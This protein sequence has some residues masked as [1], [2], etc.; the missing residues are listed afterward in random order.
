MKR[1]LLALTLLSSSLAFG[2]SMLV[3]KNGKVLTFDDQGMVYDLGNFLLPYQIKKM[4]GRYVIDEDRKLRTVDNKGLM[5][6]KEE[7]DKV[8]VNID[9]FGENYFISKFGRM[10]TVDDLGYFY[11]GEEKERE[12]R[13]VRKA[14]GNFI[15]A[16]KKVDGKEVPAIFVIT[17]Q[18]SV[19]EVNVPGLKLLQVNY[20]GGNYFT[21]N[22]GDL[23]TVSSDGFIYSKKDLGNFLGY[24]LKRGGNYFVRGH[25]LFTVAQ[26]GILTNVA[27]SSEFSTIRYFGTNFFI[28]RDGKLYTVSASG[29]LR[30]VPFN[31]PLSNISHF[32]QI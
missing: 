30:N 13:N 12:F 24:S 3:L 28:T 25:Q 8:P 17:A 7:E 2:Q 32:S 26:N 15:I 23:Y 22:S 16:D 5:Y 20:T 14:G 27:S 31:E 6:S 18:G 11:K 9:Y 21:T 10:F 4:G 19:V 1:I 29:A